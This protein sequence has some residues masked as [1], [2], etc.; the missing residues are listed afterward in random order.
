MIKPGFLTASTNKADHLG[1]SGAGLVCLSIGRVPFVLRGLGSLVLRTRVF[2]LR[3]DVGTRVGARPTQGL[4]E[5]SG[6][7]GRSSGVVGRALVAQ[8]ETKK[9]ENEKSDFFS[10]LEWSERNGSRSLS[11]EED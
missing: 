11:S 7:L 8:S 5:R 2:P 1:T 4:P 6:G 9:R 3:S 10:R